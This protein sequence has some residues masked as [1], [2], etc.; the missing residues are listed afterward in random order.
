MKKFVVCITGASGAIY[1]VR[2][3]EKLSE[4]HQVYLVVSSNG[5]IVIQRELGLDKEKFLSSLNKNVKVFDPYD[6]TASIASG[7]RIVETEGVIIAPCSL[8]TLGSIANGVSQNL[9]HRVADVALK[10]R[11]K[12]YL[13]VREMPFSLIHIENMKKVSLAGG[14]VASASPGFY[15]YPKTLDDLINFVVG[16]ILDTF[17]IPHSLYKKW[18]AE[19]TF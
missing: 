12:L 10:E 13:L 15:H 1:G 16:K 18:R 14:I 9:I 4:D 7:S 3:I 17:N 2:L 6:I 11:K 5:F 19:E 8:G